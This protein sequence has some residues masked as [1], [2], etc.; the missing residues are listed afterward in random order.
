MATSTICKKQD[1]KKKEIP[2]YNKIICHP[3]ISDIVITDKMMILTQG[4]AVSKKDIYNVLH[5]LDSIILFTYTLLERECQQMSACAE[6][7]LKTTEILLVIIDSELLQKAIW[8]TS[9]W[10][11]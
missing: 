2:L 7:S 4:M 3:D 11:T 1:T 10:H 5:F 8:H 6:T 9:L